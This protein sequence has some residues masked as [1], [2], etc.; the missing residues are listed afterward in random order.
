[1]TARTVYN[2][3]GRKILIIQN[4]NIKFFNVLFILSTLQK[5]RKIVSFFQRFW[6]YVIRNTQYYIS[7]LFNKIYNPYYSKLESFRALW[8]KTKRFNSYHS[9]PVDLL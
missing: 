4:S 1:M 9:H 8:Q 6:N 7:P 5:Y 3:P 2:I